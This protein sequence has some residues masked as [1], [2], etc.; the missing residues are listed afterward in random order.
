VIGVEDGSASN[1]VNDVQQQWP[2]GEK[3]P[4]LSGL[5]EVLKNPAATKVLRF[6]H[7]NEFTMDTVQGLALWTGCAPHHVAN[8]VEALV[9]LKILERVG[10]GEDAVYLLFGSSRGER[11]AGKAALRALVCGHLPRKAT[12]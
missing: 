1:P 6:F 7:E 11:S 4:E 8:V 12:L 3:S 5:A 9:R 10:E 2:P